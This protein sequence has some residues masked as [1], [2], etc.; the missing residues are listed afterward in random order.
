[1]RVVHDLF[2]SAN[3][4]AWNVEIFQ[5]FYRVFQ[6]VLADQTLN[7][8]TSVLNIHRPGY[9]VA[10]FGVLQQPGRI[11]GF[12][13]APPLVVTCDGDGLITILSFVKPG[14]AAAAD[15]SG[16]QRQA[17]GDGLFQVLHEHH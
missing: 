8:L 11:E 12:R 13:K 10:E 17:F 2:G 3:W 15:V 16:A 4:R 14:G 6:A 1:M 7:L 5:S 9:V